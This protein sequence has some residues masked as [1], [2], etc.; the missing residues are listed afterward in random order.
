MDIL[1][2][3]ISFNYANG[4]TADYTGI[5]LYFSGNGE[6]FTLSG[7][8][9]VTNEQYNASAGDINQLRALVK[10]EIIKQLQTQE[11][12]TAATNIEQPVNNRIEPGAE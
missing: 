3:S 11:Q 4:S 6:T 9:T 5:N 8:I 1:I 7:Y 2:T 12:P 10:D